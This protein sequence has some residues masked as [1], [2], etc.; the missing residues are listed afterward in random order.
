[1]CHKFLGDY[2]DANDSAQETF[3][4][5]YR[6]LHRFRFESA[7]STWLY[8]IAVNTCKNKLKSSEYRHRKK[9]VTLENPGVSEGGSIEIGDET[10]SPVAELERKESLVLIHK[11]IESLPTAQ[12]V[13]VV[14]RDIEGLPY[15]EIARVTGHSLGTVKSKLSRAR[16]DLRKKLRGVI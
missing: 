9:T 8:R 6:A 13:V 16:L 10:R 5:A 1:L 12:R 11:A 4:K 14:L 15:E 7:F 3:V 2:Q